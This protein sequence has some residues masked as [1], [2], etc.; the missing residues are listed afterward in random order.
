ME[1]KVK[2]DPKYKDALFTFIFGNEK[3]KE[4][5]LSLYNAINHS[6]Y[7]NVEDLEIVTLGQVL[8]IKMKNDVA[9]L[10]QNEMYLYEQQATWNPN[11]PYRFLEYVT[12]EYQK[13][14]AK[15]H[16]NKYSRRMFALP[17]PHFVVLYNGTEEQPEASE[18]RLSDMYIDGK[19]GIWKSL[20]MCTT[21]MPDTTKR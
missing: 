21:S 9:Y 18:L 3:H 20:C 12:G 13:Y 10:V 1:T 11:I 6:D 17:A 7:A 16:Y 5:A 15:R 8:L 4:F 19:K 14:L 2:A